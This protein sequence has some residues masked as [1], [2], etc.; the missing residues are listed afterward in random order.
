M[1]DDIAPPRRSTLNKSTQSLMTAEERNR[2]M[3]YGNE[4][5]HSWFADF[6]VIPRPSNA[7]HGEGDGI[8][9]ELT[10][11]MRQRRR[12]IRQRRAQAYLERPWWRFW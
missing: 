2:R 1:G 4:F 5:P 11:V 6:N 12:E 7:N 9:A 10:Q 8:A 3:K